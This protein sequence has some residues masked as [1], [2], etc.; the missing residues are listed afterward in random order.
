MSQ[1]QS[2]PANTPSLMWNKAINSTEITYSLAGTEA[3]LRGSGSTVRTP[4]LTPL[5]R[6]FV[7]IRVN[8]GGHIGIGLTTKEKSLAIGQH[9][10]TDSISWATWDN[11]GV[12]HESKCLYE[13]KL[14]EG[15]IVTVEADLS[16]LTLE[17]SINGIPYPV[18]NLPPQKEFAVA[19]SL[20]TVGSS[21]E[22]IQY[23]MF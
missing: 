1:F 21:V 8:K 12:Y 17:I 15:D 6:H 22:I 20:W 19:A 18:H 2:G 3:S 7:N 10:G 23:Q 16:H 4:C 13:K 14:K 9:L 5:R 11:I